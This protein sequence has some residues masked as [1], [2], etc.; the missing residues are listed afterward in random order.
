M[1]DAA[2]EF[3]AEDPQWRVRVGRK[4]LRAMMRPDG[5]VMERLEKAVTALQAPGVVSLLRYGFDV[6]VDDTNLLTKY[7]QNWRSVADKA[8]ARFRV[9]DL[10]AV[11]LEKCIERDAERPE[12]S[13][14]GAEMLTVL[15]DNYIAPL[16]GQGVGLV[17]PW[18]APRKPRPKVIEAAEVDH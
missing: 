5:V 14:V 11:P 9:L 2:A 10:T 4:D 16:G 8:F 17:Q 12:G 18:K 7:R 6:V 3:I 13:Q 15:Y 1:S